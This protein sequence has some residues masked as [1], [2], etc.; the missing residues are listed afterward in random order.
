MSPSGLSH[1]IA[2][3]S[4][5]GPTVEPMPRSVRVEPDVLMHQETVVCVPRMQTK[6]VLPEPF[7]SQHVACGDCVVVGNVGETDEDKP[8]PS[9]EQKTGQ[10]Q[11]TLESSNW[12]IEV[13]VSIATIYLR[14]L[15]VPKEAILYPVFQTIVHVTLQSGYQVAFMAQ[16][17]DPARHNRADSVVSLTYPEGHT[18]VLKRRVE[19]EKDR[20]RQHGRD[21]VWRHFDNLVF[22]EIKCKDVR[23]NKPHRSTDDT[24]VRLRQLCRSR[25]TK[26]SLWVV[27]DVQNLRDS[28]LKLSEA[29]LEA[30]DGSAKIEAQRYGY[31]RQNP[32]AGDF[33]EGLKFRDVARGYVRVVLDGGSEDVPEKWRLTVN[34]G[35]G[36]R[37]PV[38]I[39]NLVF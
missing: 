5:A 20:L 22:D 27:F 13:D 1:I 23:W 12:A 24:S 18:A 4:L 17:F 21:E 8:L 7:E 19:K 33:G 35:S 29:S 6:L 2:A 36:G 31:R 39:D 15:H 16:L 30:V 37:E 38:R 26:R 10:E 34:A 28:P 32:A 11:Q 14:V 9:G 3:L 25:S